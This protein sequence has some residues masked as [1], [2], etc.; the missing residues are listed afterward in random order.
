MKEYTGHLTVSFLISERSK[1]DKLL[2]ERQKEQLATLLTIIIQSSTI[3]PFR[4]HKSKYMC[5]YCRSLFVQSAKLKE[6]TDTE[7]REIEIESVIVRTLYRKSRIKIDISDLW[8]SRCED[9]FASFLD[10]FNHLPVI[11][12]I[13]LDKEICDRFECFDL[14]DD[15]MSCLDCG[16][17][18]R[19][20]GPLLHHRHKY[21]TEHFLCEICGLGFVSK[22]NVDNHVKQIHEIK[23][24]KHCSLTFPTQYSL[25][26]HVENVHMT[27]KLKCELCSE[28]LGNRYLKKRH[29]ALVHDCKSVQFI[30]EWCSKIFTRNNKYVQHISRVHYKEKNCTCEVCGHKVFN[31]DALRRHMVCH[32]DARPFKCEVCDKTFRRKKTLVI[33]MRTHKL[34]DAVIVTN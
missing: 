34:D 23:S 16:Q 32:D 11:H 9:Q 1:E 2:E 33:H 27:D 10:Y 17:Y 21:H 26:N 4:W 30:C 18:F 8:C 24:C 13:F 14:G 3:I 22:I 7:H 5:F 20:F 19:F 29:M 28:I 6:H 25:A 31:L 15:G 12:E